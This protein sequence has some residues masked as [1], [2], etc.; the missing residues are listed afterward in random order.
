[1]NLLP[2]SAWI[3][4][5]AAL[6]FPTSSALLQERRSTQFYR[7]LT[8]VD[9]SSRRSSPS[10][11]TL[12]ARKWQQYDPA[13][14]SGDTSRVAGSDSSES[15]SVTLSRALSG[16]RPTQTLTDAPGP[17]TI[18]E[19]PKIVVL[20]ATGKIGRLIIRQLLESNIDAT[21]VAFCRDYDKACRVL[22][23]DLLVLSSGSQR[24]KKN[25]PKLHIVEGD[26]VPPEELPGYSDE[27]E[28]MEWLWRATSAAKF[29]GNAVSDYDDSD[30]KAKSA[31]E[32]SNEALQQAIRGCTTVISC[33][34]AVR[35]TNLWTDLLAR[36]F[37]RLLRKDVSNWCADP[38]HPYYVHFASTRKALAYAER[39]QLRREAAVEDD[40]SSD[41]EDPRD[42]KK[43]PRIRFIRISDLCVAQ[44][45]WYF[46]PLL[47]NALHSMVFRYQELAEKLLESST[48]IETI[49]LRPGD[50]VDEERDV[51]TTSLQVSIDGR[52][53]GPARVGRD[54]V[55]ALA[56]AAAL[57][58][59]DSMRQNKGNEDSSVRPAGESDAPFHY[60]FGVRWC[61]EN[62]DPYPPQGRFVD[63][64]PN[65]N[66]CMRSALRSVRKEEKR[67]RRLR[68]RK[69]Q[70][71]P[72][73]VLRFA[74]S[75]PTVRR[76]LKPYGICVAVPVY[77]TLFMATRT[78]FNSMLPYLPGQMW[79]V[80][81]IARIKSNFW[82]VGRLIL[83][84]LTSALIK[85]SALISWIPRRRNYISF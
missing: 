42:Q 6:T 40:L 32:D 59:S 85:V 15:A 35:P 65:A 43:V 18:P 47:T 61:G 17:P 63:G 38:R 75:L 24:Q 80:P 48:M 71:Y 56:V 39:E 58:D 45:P 21:I 13:D 49:V 5:V 46:I 67:S 31:E 16:D 2:L 4:L 73:H 36:P 72:P 28:T 69:E 10:R 77:L 3:L 62:L 9:S 54:D 84:H 22:Y 23:D 76:R 52:V 26:L 29:Y 51:N 81:T 8:G 78:V 27:E 19:K 50:L 12:S 7:T 66:L 83:S 41:K 64:L 57:F 25:G 20:G 11:F 1:M 53:P 79:I 34:G 37:W 44:R 14:E 82:A 68:L 70:A 74:R 30:T 33:V 60:T 55:A